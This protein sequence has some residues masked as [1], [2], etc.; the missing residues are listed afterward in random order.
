MNLPRLTATTMQPGFREFHARL[1]IETRVDALMLAEWI[2][3]NLSDLR[4]RFNHCDEPV[5]TDRRVENCQGIWLRQ[6][7]LSRKV[8]A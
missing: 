5:D 6:Q 8:S 1:F 4:D 7:F 3:A 2:R